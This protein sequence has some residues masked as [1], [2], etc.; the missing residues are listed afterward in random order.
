MGEA[1]LGWVRHHMAPFYTAGADASWAS[2]FGEAAEGNTPQSH[3]SVPLTLLLPLR[4]YSQW[5]PFYVGIVLSQTLTE[6]TY[7]WGSK[8][9]GRPT[10]A[11]ED[12]GSRLLV[13]Q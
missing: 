13:G 4:D 7:V 12:C 2:P 3:V 5:K 1:E 10:S 9:R 6:T 8:G 11:G